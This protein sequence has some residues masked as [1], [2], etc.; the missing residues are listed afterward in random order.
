M[1]IPSVDFTFIYLF[2]FFAIPG[3]VFRKLYYQGEFSKQF[4]SKNWAYTLTTSFLL[5]III[6]FISF[7]SVKGFFQ[8]FGKPISKNYLIRLSDFKNVKDIL[9]GLSLYDFNIYDKKIFIIFCYTIITCLVSFLSALICWHFVRRLKLDRKYK[10]LR[11]GNIWNYYLRGEIIDFKDFVTIKENK[12]VLLTLV[13]IIISDGFSENKL[14]SGILTQYTIDTN[15]NLETI[16]L[17]DSHLWKK[18]KK[19]DSETYGRNVK[20]KVKG[21]CLILDVKK[22]IDLNLTYVY[23]DEISNS[24]RQKAIKIINLIVILFYLIFFIFAITSSNPLLVINSS[25]FYTILLKLFL[26]IILTLIF[27]IIFNIITY[28]QFYREWRFSKKSETKKGIVVIFI[29]TLVLMFIYRLIRYGD[30]AFWSL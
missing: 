22:S 26:I 9:E 16:T 11:F 17:T 23:G 28:I 4:I 1:E 13:D 30:L 14:F 3:L 29:F 8:V 18:D 15:N 21:H 12:K 5:G 19:Q 25:I 7:Y 24:I 20:T 6:Q 27:S 10:L 2:L